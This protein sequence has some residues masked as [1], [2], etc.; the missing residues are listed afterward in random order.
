MIRNLQ[1]SLRGRPWSG[2]LMPA[3]FAFLLAMFPTLLVGIPVPIIEDEWGYLLSADT[4]CQGRLSNPTHEHWTLLESVHQMQVPSYQSK[5]PPGQALFLAAGQLIWH[6]I[7]GVWLSVAFMIGAIVWMLQAFLP[8]RWSWLGGS[9]AAALYVVLGEPFVGGTHGYWSQSYWGGAVAA[10]GGALV[11]GAVARLVKRPRIWTSVTM[12]L[13]LLLLANT[14]P[15]EGL[16]A[17]LPLG[18]VLVQQLVRRGWTSYLWVRVVLP[19]V[20]ILSIGFAGMLRYNQ[21]VTGDART[22]PWTVHYEQY[23]IFPLFIWQETLPDKDWHHPELA[24]FYGKVERG[25]HER[26][27][28]PGGLAFATASKIY[29]F[30]RFYLGPIFLLPFLVG[31]WSFRRLPLA[32]ASLASIALVLGS[33]LIKFGS[34]PHYSAPI[35]AL[36]IAL[37]VAGLRQLWSWR[38]AETWSGKR[39]VFALLGLGLAHTAWGLKLSVDNVH[40]THR[41]LRYKATQELLVSPGKDLVFVSY[42]PLHR[43]GEHWI[44]NDADIDSS[45]IVWIRDPGPEERAKVQADFPGRKVWLSEVEYEARSYRLIPLGTSGP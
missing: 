39:V 34:P 41:E 27:K 10:G 17:S 20:L 26:H 13:G 2:V 40:R 14:R 19:A 15:M 16:L 1:N 45:E 43:E 9:I 29:R 25:M 33:N 5:Y 44:W 18:L 11:F 24:V 32:W 22:M 28:T 23:C 21:A 8:R 38:R 42:G 6:P 30:W 36:V 7:L 35:T 3:L 37:I 4:F 12:A 31:A